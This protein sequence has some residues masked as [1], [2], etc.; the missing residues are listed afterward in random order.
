MLFFGDLTFFDVVGDV[1]AVVVVLVAV[2]VF[3]CYIHR[4]LSYVVSPASNTYIE[5]CRMS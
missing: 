2:V 1:V 3:C 4:G 5:G